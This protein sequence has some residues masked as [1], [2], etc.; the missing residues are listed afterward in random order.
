MQG[1]LVSSRQTTF[2]VQH[3]QTSNKESVGCPERHD[4]DCQKQ[5]KLLG[6]VRR[7]TRLIWLGYAKSEKSTLAQLWNIWAFS[8]S[9]QTSMTVRQR[10]CPTAST[11]NA[12]RWRLHLLFQP[13]KFL[14]RFYSMSLAQVWAPPF[15]LVLTPAMVEVGVRE[16]Y[17]GRDCP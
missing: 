15:E 8:T 16:T 9:K 12:N 6:Q 4:Q 7:A 13:T 14:A 11:L 5:W 10:V 3:F 2:L 1:P 17:S